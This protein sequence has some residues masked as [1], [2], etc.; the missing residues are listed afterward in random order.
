MSKLQNNNRACSPDKDASSQNEHGYPSNAV[1]PSVAAP[2]HSHE[3][4]SVSS[5]TSTLNNNN[6]LLPPD[7]SMTTCN[8]TLLADT[9]SAEGPI[10]TAVA[11]AASS[12]PPAAL[13]SPQ[14][15]QRPLGESVMKQEDH[16]HYIGGEREGDMPNAMNRRS[17]FDGNNNTCNTSS[18]SNTIPSAPILSPFYQPQ[19]P[20]HPQT[21]A[22]L[23]ATRHPNAAAVAAMSSG[24]GGCGDPFLTLVPIA[25]SSSHHAAMHSSCD[26]HQRS[27]HS[28]KSHP[29]QPS[30][31]LYGRGGLVGLQSFPQQESSPLTPRA[32]M[33]IPPPP[34]P[35][36]Q[37]NLTSSPSSAAN[38][39]RQHNHYQLQGQLLQMQRSVAST[40]KSDSS[41]GGSA[42]GL[43]NNNNS[44]CKSSAATPTAV[45]AFLF[46][47]PSAAGI[48]RGGEWSPPTPTDPQEN[49]PTQRKNTAQRIRP[50][51]DPSAALQQQHQQQQQHTIYYLQYNLAESSFG[52]V[53][54]GQQSEAQFG[55]PMT[56]PPPPLLL[57]A[58]PQQPSMPLASAGEGMALGVGMGFEIGGLSRS[59]TCIDAPL[60]TLFPIHEIS[61]TAISDI[62]AG[63][64]AVSSDGGTCDTPQT[65]GTSAQP[66]SR[67]GECANETQRPEVASDMINAS[68]DDHCRPPP[69]LWA[70]PNNALPSQ[71]AVYH[72]YRRTNNPSLHR[73]AERVLSHPS[74]SAA[75]AP[76][77]PMVAKAMM[78][79]R[80]S[81]GHHFSANTTYDRMLP[82]EYSMTS[83]VAPQCNNALFSLRQQQ[84]QESPLHRTN[85][86][87][88]ARSSPRQCTH[89]SSKTGDA[90]VVWPLPQHQCGKPPLSPSNAAHVRIS[91]N[92]SPQ[93]PPH[94]VAFSP[95]VSARAGAG[96]F[97]PPPPPESLIL[98]VSHQSHHDSRQTI[99]TANLSAIGSGAVA[100]EGIGQWAAVR[101]PSRQVHSYASTC[102]SSNN[103]S[104][105]SS[106]DKRFATGAQDNS[107]NNNNTP[108]GLVHAWG[109][110][111]G[112]FGVGGGANFEAL[113]PLPSQCAAA[114]GNLASD[115]SEEEDNTLTYSL[116]ANNAFYFAGTPPIRNQTLSNEAALASASQ[117]A[118]LSSQSGPFAP[119]PAPFVQA[120]TGESTTHLHQEVAALNNNV[121]HAEL[122]PWHH[123]NNQLYFY[124]LAGASTSSV[125]MSPAACISVGGC[126]AG[127]A[128]GI[129]S[130]LCV[131]SA[132]GHTGN[133]NFLL[134]PADASIPSAV[135][136]SP[137]HPPCIN[138]V[139]LPPPP[140][141]PPLHPTS[142]LKMC[143]GRA[144]SGDLNN[145]HRSRD[146]VICA[147]H[148]EHEA[149]SDDEDTA[150]AEGDGGPDS[151]ATS[152]STNANA[153]TSAAPVTSAATAGAGSATPSSTPR[154]SI[155]P[156]N[157]S[158]Y[159][160]FSN[161]RP[162]HT[163]PS[164]AYFSAQA[165]ETPVH[166]HSVT[167]KTVTSGATTTY[168]TP[169]SPPRTPVR[170]PLN[171]PETAT[172]TP[173]KEARHNVYNSIQYQQPSFACRQG[174][175]NYLQPG[176]RLSVAYT[177]RNWA[178]TSACPQNAMDLNPRAL[179]N[180]PSAFVDCDVTPS[181][182]ARPPASAFI[183]PSA[184]TYGRPS[185]DFLGGA[186][187]RPSGHAAAEDNA[188][189]T[190]E[191][192]LA[193]CGITP[194]PALRAR[195]M[196]PHAADVND[197]G[198]LADC[199][200]G[201]LFASEEETPSLVPSAC[202]RGD[203]GYVE[204][205]VNMDATTAAA[206][207]A[208]GDECHRLVSRRPGTPP[209]PMGC[210]R[211]GDPIHLGLRIDD[212]ATNNTIDT[213][214][215]KNAGPPPV[216]AKS[217]RCDE[218]AVDDVISPLFG[219][220]GGDSCLP[221]TLV[222][223]EWGSQSPKNV[224]ADGPEAK[225]MYDTVNATFGI[226]IGGVGNN[227]TSPN[228]SASHS[229]SSIPHQFIRARTAAP[230][231]P[232]MFPL[233]LT[234]PTEELSAYA[235]TG[236]EQR[237]QP[238]QQ[239]LRVASLLG[240]PAPS[241]RETPLAF[242]TTSMA[243]A[244][245]MLMASQTRP[246]SCL[247]GFERFGGGNA[248]GAAQ[249]H[250][251]SRVVTR[252]SIAG[253]LRSQQAEE[254]VVRTLVP[255]SRNTNGGSTNVCISAW[256]PS[257]GVAVSSG[258]HDFSAKIEDDKPHTL[259]PNLANPQHDDQSS[260]PFSATEEI[261]SPTKNA[262][263]ILIPRQRESYPH[264]AAQPVAKDRTAGAHETSASEGE[265]ALNQ[266]P[267]GAS[268]TDTLGLY[269]GPFDPVA[270]PPPIAPRFATTLGHDSVSLLELPRARTQAYVLQNDEF[271]TSGSSQAFPPHPAPTTG[272]ETGF[273]Q[274]DAHPPSGATPPLPPNPFLRP[275]GPS[276]H[277]SSGMYPAGSATEACDPPSNRCN[278]PETIESRAPRDILATKPTTGGSPFN[279]GMGFLDG[280]TALHSGCNDG[281]TFSPS[282]INSAA[283]HSGASASSNF[284]PPPPP[285]NPYHP[286]NIENRN[287][288]IQQLVPH[289]TVVMRRH[290]T[291]KQPPKMQA[292]ST[293]PLPPF[294]Y[295]SQ[296][297]ACAGAPSASGASFYLGGGMA[298]NATSTSNVCMLSGL[299][300]AADEGS[301]SH[302]HAFAAN[303]I[304]FR[305]EGPS[306][307]TSMSLG[308]GMGSISPP[309]RNARVPAAPAP[310]PM[311][312]LKH[313]RNTPNNA[314][315]EIPNMAV[316][317]SPR[318]R[319]A[320]NA[321]RKS[322]RRSAATLAVFAPSSMYSS[323]DG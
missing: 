277:A 301:L 228:R 123:Q 314:Q 40:C 136:P 10:A 197:I 118:A 210:L 259:G 121:L 122:Q 313:R 155:N 278:L 166:M 111:R 55:Y 9:F 75:P 263:G 254:D 147:P 91:M 169:R 208:R 52:G 4:R 309:A 273:Q 72:V 54:G 288:A 285:P 117:S 162:S 157:N 143:P 272:W 95:M 322:Q 247:M 303:P 178:N 165:F 156:S 77:S 234:S 139:P 119:P 287:V 103:G 24:V 200:K 113:A 300:P 42:D 176:D 98:V 175:N 235:Q 252:I 292:T 319:T 275:V 78:S 134:L 219:L 237:E 171:W 148:V 109:S 18:A 173:V 302:V 110:G 312:S 179:H 31:F 241:C 311:S 227:I 1:E 187:Q 35:P 213:N 164:N 258:S 186:A 214:V 290:A 185:D 26:S 226:G 140:P 85:S 238:H 294:I 127:L 49:L 217:T 215:I 22:V 246:A 250:Q 193:M 163:T 260:P 223:T 17:D 115:A 207:S 231:I 232:P 188:N 196:M 43:N 261:I 12:L 174:N 149:F 306:P 96:N 76:V 108:R 243:P 276:Q 170:A 46:A 58:A 86:K 242:S 284:A 80:A 195:P 256:Q 97:P 125:G 310:Q 222:A 71:A 93:L 199:V 305:S 100:A 67:H 201:S 249:S 20:C 304:T 245:G 21:H 298:S 70:A 218:G 145:E 295:D 133:N 84:Q 267:E 29:H 269:R 190:P 316:D 144:L 192:D 62:P 53:G 296:R 209:P 172:P 161:A 81:S 206:C 308:T 150:T 28:R 286:S 128:Y 8:V 281:T 74:P 16:F 48:L 94:S 271:E 229:S 154:A 177:N 44:A 151:K 30:V 114:G 307:G 299:T 138:N 167:P 317:L 39:L 33:P 34:I 270:P 244:G 60:Q 15:Q 220:E 274:S 146:D 56:A 47:S 3:R 158:K 184:R 320:R 203:I 102:N 315:R 82:P 141:T 268:P 291:A 321:S 239:T 2:P 240:R 137:A 297:A 25:S 233:R 36:H 27:P 264:G 38:V 283:R 61:S 293:P 88:S 191:G 45:S 181:R 202:P 265:E 152:T 57:V 182:P 112:L 126:G 89:P 13:F 73:H 160:R 323:D 266:T 79:S 180:S 50:S 120:H 65:E 129:P 318:R 83:S 204:Y 248:V 14:I 59:D 253:D 198:A 63:T 183:S 251:P 168:I 205:L 92:A 236:G 255:A 106:H 11:A 6:L 142:S 224:T 68:A 211:L 280:S 282:L 90:P 99:T 262:C 230:P 64:A 116:G 189:A 104:D 279:L 225:N 69:H 51:S 257:E 153:S 5:S 159:L 37:P 23:R 66:Q 7:L 135:V 41:E 130:S 216:Y 32:M 194:N 131:S 19:L 212:V 105:G 221:L 132:S 107:N 101:T 124:H 289:P 87:T